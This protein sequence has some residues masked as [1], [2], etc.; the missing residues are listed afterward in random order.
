VQGPTPLSEKTN[1][2]ITS[3]PARAEKLQ[4]SKKRKADDSAIVHNHNPVISQASDQP[5]TKK[6]KAELAKAAKDAA[7]KAT[8]ALLDVS[9]ITLEDEDPEFEIPVFDTCDV[10]RRK[11]RTFLTKNSLTQAAFLRA[12]AVAAHGPGASAI[13]SG[14][15]NSFMKLKGPV[16]GNTNGTYYTAYV[17]FEKLRVKQRKPKSKDREEMEYIYPNGVDT[18]TLLN[19]QSYIVSVGTELGMDKYGQVRPINR[20]PMFR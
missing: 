14:S 2:N 4:S 16:S 12:I 15:Y 5:M 1:L 7:K 6:A 13:A 10:V 8:E 11:I 17:F 9:D 19:N 18:K 3:G 20:F